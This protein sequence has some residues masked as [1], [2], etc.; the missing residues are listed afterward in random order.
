MACRDSACKRAA[1]VEGPLKEK[2][3]ETMRRTFWLIEVPSVKNTYKVHCIIG[4]LHTKN[5]GPNLSCKFGWT[6]W[7]IGMQFVMK[8]Q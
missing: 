3:F 4:K 8:E 7:I 6:L 1:R 2:L 5:E